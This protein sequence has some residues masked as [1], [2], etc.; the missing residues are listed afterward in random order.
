MAEITYIPVTRLHPHPD[1]PRKDLGDLSELAASIK[2]NGIFQN[3]T[4]VD[5]DPTEYVSDYTVIIGH[6]RLAAAKLAGLTELPCVIVEMTPAEQVQ[7]MLLENMQRSDL[8]VYEQAQGFQMMLDFGY[9]V[10]QVAEKSGFSQ[11]TVRRRVKMMEL[12]QDTLKEVSVRQIS[13]GDFDDLAKID[14]L[15]LRN[16]ALKEIGTVNFREELKKA[17]IEDDTAKKLP[18]VKTWLKKAGAKKITNQ[19]SWSKDYLRD[20]KGHSFSNIWIDQLG[21]E[22]N[23]F[24]PDD[25]VEGKTLF[26]VIDGRRLGLYVDPQRAAR[27]STKKSREQ[28]D[29]EK[30]QREAKKAIREISAVHYELRKAFVEKLT[31]TTKNREAVLTGALILALYRGLGSGGNHNL[32]PI[33][34]RMG[35][36]P[37]EY[38]TAPIVQGIGKVLE[39][40]KDLARAIYELYDDGPEESFAHNMESPGWFPLFEETHNTTLTL[41]YNW[42]ISLGYEM[43]AEELAMFDGTHRLY[44]VGEEHK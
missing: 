42:L 18:E 19:E 32:K 22:N 8:T 16:R 44:H 33:T 21:T 36:R 14:D 29:R 11:A 6:R 2:E 43:S 35:V 31:V 3:L 27:T 20:A 17:Q 9:T 28:L 15:S 1:N 4:V 12:D 30:A 37:Y 24:P 5:D 39:H 25:L 34:E 40:E 10:E 41:L 13:L 23:K 7:T 38:K 26:Y